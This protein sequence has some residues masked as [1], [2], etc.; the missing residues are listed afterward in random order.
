MII[1][2]STIDIWNTIKDI[3][4]IS[5]VCTI[6][7]WMPIDWEEPKTPYIFISKV[8]DTTQTQSNQ[9]YLEK[10]ARI[11]F[12]IVWNSDDYDQSTIET[13]KNTITN[14]LVAEAC[15]KITG[16]N[17]VTVSDITEDTESPLLYN[18]KER[19]YLVK[20]YLF[21]YDALND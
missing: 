5:N 4:N 21:T 18:N 8:S 9:W 12:T 20:D 19:Q 2:I 11:S 3:A 7:N 1:A 17:W 6:F 16:F 14:E 15:P 13:I 10:L